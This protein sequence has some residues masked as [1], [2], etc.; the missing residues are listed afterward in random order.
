MGNRLNSVAAVSCGVLCAV[1]ASA[2]TGDFNNDGLVDCQDMS[3]L[4][5]E[6]R[7]PSGQSQ[8]D[9]DDNGTIDVNDRD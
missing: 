8:F 9:L 6:I 3:L 5:A 2:Q 7:E 1:A 4:E